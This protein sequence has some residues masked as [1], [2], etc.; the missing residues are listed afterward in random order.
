MYCE[1]FMRV[2]SCMWLNLICYW[3]DLA[4][5]IISVNTYKW[6]LLQERSC[7][8]WQDYDIEYILGVYQNKEHDCIVVLYI[9]IIQKLYLYFSVDNFMMYKSLESNGMSMQ[10]WWNNF[11]IGFFS[12]IDKEQAADEKIYIPGKIHSKWLY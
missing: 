6:I 11:L 1:N 12:V 10:R 5:V 9:K 7:E 3:D 8:V 4:Y 2:K